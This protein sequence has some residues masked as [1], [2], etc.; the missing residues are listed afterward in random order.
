MV[1]YL[2]LFMCAEYSFNFFNLYHSKAFLLDLM[3]GHTALVTKA[4][5]GL[6]E[7]LDRM[8]I[9]LFHLARIKIVSVLRC[10]MNRGPQDNHVRPLTTAWAT[11]R[12]TELGVVCTQPPTTMNST[13]LTLQSFTTTST[14]SPFHLSIKLLLHLCSITASSLPI[15]SRPHPT[16]PLLLH[17][18]LVT[19]GP[20]SHSSDPLQPSPPFFLLVFRLFSAM[21]LF[22][23]LAQP[24]DT[25]FSSTDS[26]HHLII[27]SWTYS[28]H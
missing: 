12:A 19:P 27:F 25:N 23:P 7:D 20:H 6:T 24:L 16:T 2:Y 8:W 1:L 28:T 3:D 21:C 26:I 10:N 5:L 4:Y 14:H 18:T 22:L 9:I 11:M 15:L 13:I 17:Q